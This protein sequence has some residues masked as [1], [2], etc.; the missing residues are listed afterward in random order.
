MATLYLNGIDTEAKLAGRTFEVSKLNEETGD[1]DTMK[2]PL[3]DL[4]R[5]VVAGRPAITVPM[6]QACAREG[7][8]VAFV[9]SHGRWVGNF[10]PDSNGHAL[11]RLRQYELAGDDDFALRVAKRCVGAKLRN[12]RRVLQRLAANRELSQQPEQTAVCND[13]LAT[14]KNADAASDIETLR[15]YEGLGAAVYFRRLAAFFP[16]NLPFTG[17]N[18]RPPRDAAN[19][20]LSWTYAILLGEIDAA[21]RAAGLDPCL[22][23]LHEVSHGRASLALD[24]LEPLRPAL[25]DLL[26]L[27]ILN[28]G[29]L[30]AEYFETNADDGGVYLKKESRKIF[31]TEYER[32]ML[33]RFA[34]AKGQPHTDY[35]GVIRE[36]VNTI[37]RAMDNREPETLFEMP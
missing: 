34:P 26:V 2:V 30:Q 7:V 20:L 12:A 8:P 27:N 17:R 9:T 35:R 23:F 11:R 36:Q 28:H 15:G 32:T 5:V 21:I 18:R 33:R 3:F 1:I 29:I 37:I 25:C 4:D 6:L 13:L 19:A 31:F 10:V 14:L 22:G 16:E 24:L